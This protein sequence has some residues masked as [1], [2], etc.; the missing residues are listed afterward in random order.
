MRADSPEEGGN[1][2]GAVDNVD[3]AAAQ[4]VGATGEEKPEKRKVSEAAWSGA[5]IIGGFF[6]IR[7]F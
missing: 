4:Q 3:A 5:K 7:E 2:R 1:D 6:D